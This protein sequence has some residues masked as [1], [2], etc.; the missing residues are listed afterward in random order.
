LKPKADNYI[1]M[2]SMFFVKL[3]MEALAVDYFSTVM[4]NVQAG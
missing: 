1:V 4:P 2:M 3:K